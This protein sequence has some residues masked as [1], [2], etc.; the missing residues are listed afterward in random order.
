MSTPPDRRHELSST[1]I[2]Q[3]HSNQDELTR[4]HIQDQMI[5]TSMGGVLPEQSNPS[6]FRRVLDIGCGTG[7][8]LIQAA[9]TYPD[10]S[11]LVGVDTNHTMIEYARAQAKE[12]H[13]S[14]RVEFH[15]MDVLLMIEFPAEFFDLVNERFAMSFVRTWEWSKLL[16]EFQRVTRPDGII[17]L[18]ELDANVQSNSPA[19]TRLNDMFNQALSRSGHTFLSDHCGDTTELVPLLTRHGFHQLTTQE[20]RIDFR[21]GT[22]EGQRFYEDMAR[23]YR[24]IR[25]FLRQWLR[26]PDDYE[27]IYQQAIHDMQQPD[28]LATWQLL[29]VWGNISSKS[30]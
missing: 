24:T 6:S 20:H 9:K 8:W 2:V 30:E 7:D 26:V 23:L 17:R 1:Y 15:T 5:T 11:L 19:L 13:V 21:A 28:F 22:I 25:P 10:I 18:T 12:H 14:E 27:T 4:L 29:T 3:D 16:S